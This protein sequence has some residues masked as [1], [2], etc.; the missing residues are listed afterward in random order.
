M[1]LVRNLEKNNFAR[2]FVQQY[3]VR[4]NIHCQNKGEQIC[5]TKRIWI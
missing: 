3:Q 5:Q 4:V 2:N 1:E